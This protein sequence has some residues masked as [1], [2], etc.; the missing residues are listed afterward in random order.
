MK[1]DVEVPKKQKKEK[2]K[3]EESAPETSGFTH[4]ID[5]SKRFEQVNLLPPLMVNEIDDTIKQL[6]ERI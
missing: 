2:K 6:K 3:K 1:D 5:I 4:H